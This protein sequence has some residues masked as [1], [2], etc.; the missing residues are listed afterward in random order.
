MSFNISQ[1]FI[2]RLAAE[3]TRKFH[4]FDSKLSLITET[5]I[6]LQNDVVPK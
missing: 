5:D 2:F 4:K 3:K 1:N 6:Y